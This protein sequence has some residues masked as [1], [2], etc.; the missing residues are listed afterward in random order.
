MQETVHLNQAGR[1]AGEGGA[2]LWRNEGAEATEPGD[3]WRRWMRKKE[4]TV[5][6][7]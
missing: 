3:N 2:E 6:L 7:R 4:S 5:N 1:E